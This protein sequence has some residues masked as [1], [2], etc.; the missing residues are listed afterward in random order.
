MEEEKIAGLIMFTLGILGILDVF[1]AISFDLYPLF[2][3]AIT[4]TGILL[5]IFD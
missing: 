1:G 4:G 5:I 3:G 2:S